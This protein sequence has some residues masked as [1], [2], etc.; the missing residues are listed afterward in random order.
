MV[1]VIRGGHIWLDCSTGGRPLRGPGG[2]GRR[3]TRRWPAPCAGCSATAGWRWA[4]GCRPSGSWPRRSA[5]AGPRSPPRTGELRDQRPPDQPARRRQLDVRCPPGQRVGHAGLWLPGR[6]RGDLIDLGCAAL[7]APPQ[8]RPRRPAALEDLPRYAG[9]AGYHPTGLAE[10]REAVAAPVRRRA[11]C[12]PAADQIMITNGVQHAVDLLLRLLVAP[13]AVGAGRVADLPERARRARGPTGPG[14]APTT[15]TRRRLG[16]RDCCSARSV[17]PADAGVP[18]PGLPEPDR[19]PHAGRAARAAG[20]RRPS[21]PAPTWSVDESF[22]DLPPSVPSTRR[23]SPRSTGTPGCSP[24]GGMSKP[25]WGGL[26]IGWIRAPAPVVARLAALRVTRRHRRSGA[27]PAGRRPAAGPGRRDPA[28]PPGAARPAARRPGRRAPRR[29]AEL[30]VPPSRSAASACGSSWTRPVSTALAHAALAHGVRL[31]PGPRFGMDG[32]LER[33]RA[34][35]VHPAAGGPARS[36]P[37]TGDRR[38]RSR[39]GPPR[40]LVPPALVA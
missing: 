15:S 40:P 33:Y 14:S 30:D 34:A 9:G 11:A 22:V 24:I 2:A 7:A 18:D 35:A 28:G 32:T 39:P 19:P 38:L 6:R 27:G 1:S 10:L 8:L 36:G 20:R 23:R 26:R 13:G 17:R 16:A 37:P 31:A 3:S 12:R 4:C 25:Y 5:S 21:R 29:A